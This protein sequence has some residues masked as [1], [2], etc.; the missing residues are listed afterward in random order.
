MEHMAATGFFDDMEL[1]SDV[2]NSYI[3]LSPRIKRS[4]SSTAEEME[5]WAF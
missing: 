1:F 4:V 2:D 3:E 5:V